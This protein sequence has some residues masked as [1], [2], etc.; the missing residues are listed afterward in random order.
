MLKKR[1]RRRE[2]WEKIKR[3]SERERASERETT[4]MHGRGNRRR[5]REEGHIRHAEGEMEDR[6]EG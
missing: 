4:D 3:G 2:G 5:Q 6:T 1:N